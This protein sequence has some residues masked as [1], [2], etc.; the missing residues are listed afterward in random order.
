M[1]MNG[2]KNNEKRFPLCQTYRKKLLLS[3]VISKKWT[4]V[5]LLILGTKHHNEN[6]L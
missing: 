4:E 2:I 1:Y 5:Y 3:S 6:Q